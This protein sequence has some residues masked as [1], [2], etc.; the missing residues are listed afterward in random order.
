MSRARALLVVAA[1]IVGSLSGWAISGA[2]NSCEYSCPAQ[3]PCFP[4]QH[5]GAALGS[6]RSAVL[7]GLIALA[8]F[9][10]GWILLA[11]QQ[12]RE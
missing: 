5:C 6:V 10:I 4:P 9:G 3:P 11:V 1:A 7:G 12:P 8:V 2:H